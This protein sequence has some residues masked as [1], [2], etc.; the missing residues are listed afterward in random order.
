MRSHFHECVFFN[1]AEFSLE[2]LEWDLTFFLDL[3]NQ[4]RQ[5]GKDLKMGRLRFIKL[6]QYVS[7]LHDGLVKR[8]YK[9][10]A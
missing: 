3:G 7:S 5:V 8:L 4:K 6:N 10:D 9:V 2:L 1:R